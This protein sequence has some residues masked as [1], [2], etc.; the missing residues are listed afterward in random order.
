[1]MKLAVARE[2][3]AYWRG[4]HRLTDVFTPGWINAKVAALIEVVASET[5]LGSWG[6]LPSPK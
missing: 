3:V 1:M 4:R 6:L 2:T 5:L